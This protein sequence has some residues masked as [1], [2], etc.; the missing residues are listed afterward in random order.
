MSV[1]VS[2]NLLSNLRIDTRSGKTPFRKCCLD[3]YRIS[4]TLLI[5]GDHLQHAINHHGLPRSSIRKPVHKAI[6][7]VRLL[8]SKMADNE[9]ILDPWSKTADALDQQLNELVEF[10]EDTE[11]HDTFRLFYI[12]RTV[13]ALKRILDAT[14][15]L[16]QNWIE[17]RQLL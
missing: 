8:L 2:E 15:E 3:Q 12:L 14:N 11:A 1:L 13:F 10:L 6:Q 16:N 4:S 7:E 5:L 17:A 9:G